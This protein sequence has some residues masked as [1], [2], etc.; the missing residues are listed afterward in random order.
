[1]LRREKSTV[2]RFPHR[3]ERNSF[4]VRSQ[5]EHR[6]LVVEIGEWVGWVE[7]EGEM[8]LVDFAELVDWWIGCV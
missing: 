1:M 8:G 7:L 3:I 5:D 2:V 6:S 4:W